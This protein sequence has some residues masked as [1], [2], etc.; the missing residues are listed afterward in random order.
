LR[1]KQ[2]SRLFTRDKDMVG[3]D[4]QAFQCLW[5]PLPT[6]PGSSDDCKFQTPLQPSCLS[7]DRAMLVLLFLW[8]CW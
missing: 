6:A 7:L 3:R 5:P 4:L 8:C 1:Y 2:S